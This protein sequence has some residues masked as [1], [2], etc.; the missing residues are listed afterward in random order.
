MLRRALLI[1]FAMVT[2]SCAGNTLRQ[3]LVYTAWDKCQAEGR[4]PS[5]VIL[6]RVDLDGRYW[7]QGLAGSYGFADTQKC[8][9]EQVAKMGQAP[10][11]GL[12]SAP[13]APV[14]PEVLSAQ[15]AVRT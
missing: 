1:L 9:S 8:I 5:Q 2:V 12:A 15:V 7:I 4:I 13:A 3:D 11:P 10:P 14:T 6:T